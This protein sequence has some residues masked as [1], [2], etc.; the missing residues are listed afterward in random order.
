VVVGAA[1][2]AVALTLVRAPVP[3][4]V[5]AP[6]PAPVSVLRGDNGVRSVAFSS[7]G[8]AGQPLPLSGVR[9]A[10]FSPDGRTLATV[11]GTFNDVRFWDLA[12]RRQ[13]GATLAGPVGEVTAMTFGPDGRTVAT[14]E[15][16]GVVRLYKTP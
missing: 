7:D 13:L 3:A 8:R 5:A 4:V 1:L 15:A 12:E 6:V 11:S 14:A 9:Q 10:E 2:V 16:D